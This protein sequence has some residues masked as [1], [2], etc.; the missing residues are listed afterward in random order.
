MVRDAILNIN[1]Y[2]V[3]NAFVI[4]FGSSMVRREFRNLKVPGS[5]PASTI[6][7]F[8]FFFFL[9]LFHIIKL[10]TKQNNSNTIQNLFFFFF[11]F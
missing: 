7:L 10:L 5:N 11:F 8:V 1:T 9:F 6:C 3:T 2:F 4:C